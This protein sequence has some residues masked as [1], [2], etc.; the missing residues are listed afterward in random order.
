MLPTSLVA[1][2]AA[3]LVVLSITSPIVVPRLIYDDS[4]PVVFHGV[5]LLNP[6]LR[7]GE[8]LYYEFRYSRRA[9]CESVFEYE[10]IRGADIYPF[11]LRRTTQRPPGQNIHAKTSIPLPPD[12]GPG[13]YVFRFRGTYECKGASKTLQVTSPP[14]AIE[15]VE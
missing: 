10:L 7:A 1:A 14:S 6:E 9:N 13:K 8:T 11:G 4:A 3:A 12:V 2:I 5:T 15:I